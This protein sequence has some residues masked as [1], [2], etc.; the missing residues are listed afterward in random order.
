MLKS[1]RV[2]GILLYTASLTVQWTCA[3]VTLAAFGIKMAFIKSNASH[4]L[5][6][7]PDQGRYLIRT[8]M[9]FVIHLPSDKMSKQTVGPLCGWG[10]AIKVSR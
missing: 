7:S 5:L 6:L 10:K 2:P 8:Q 1:F 3:S 9:L 4:R